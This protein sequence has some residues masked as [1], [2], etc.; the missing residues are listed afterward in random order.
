MGRYLT[1]LPRL[2]ALAIDRALNEAIAL[3]PK[4]GERLAAM[5]GRRLCLNL[6]GLGIDLFIAGHQ[7]RLEVSVDDSQPADT[8]ISGTPTALLAMS[9]PDWRAPGSGVR[10]EGD[11]A[12]AQALE[13]L[14]RQLDPD[15]EALLSRQLGEVLGHQVWRLL[16][17]ALAA[18]RHGSRVAGDQ[19]ARYLREESGLLVT[20]PEVEDFVRSVDE[21]RE[22]S[23]RLE[24]RLRRAGRA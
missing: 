19:L 18:G 14:F 6:Q 21:L 12:A 22:A 5:N 15:W 10:I 4:P 23:D 7:Q 8:T 13:R 3:D 11:A 1:P 20:R 16:K 17:D 9:L 2:F 24:A